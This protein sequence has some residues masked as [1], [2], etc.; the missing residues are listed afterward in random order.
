AV[1]VSWGANDRLT[2]HVEAGID[3]HSVTRKRLELANELPIAGIGI[4]GYALNPSR[5][6]YVR[7]RWDVGS[8][9]IETFVKTSLVV[10][11]RSWNSPA[12]RDRSYQQHVGRRT[13]NIEIS[14]DVFLQDTGRK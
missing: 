10:V 1:G 3:D 7:D 8:K 2:S 12:R 13:V 14:L 4:L 6:I 5:I 11:T 9:N